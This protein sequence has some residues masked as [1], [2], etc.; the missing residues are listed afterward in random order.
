MVR[1]A[2]WT[3]QKLSVIPTRSLHHSSLHCSSISYL[4][5]AGTTIE[6]FYLFVLTTSRLRINQFLIES[7]QLIHLIRRRVVISTSFLDHEL[8]SNARE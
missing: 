1:T 5:L 3:E 8:S 4:R 2:I 7:S 6:T